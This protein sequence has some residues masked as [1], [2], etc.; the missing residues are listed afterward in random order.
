MLLAA[1]ANP[2]AQLKLSPP[3]RNIGNDRGLDGMLTTGATPLLRAAKALDAPAIAALLAKGA[4]LSAGQLARHHA[5]HGGG[6]ARLGRRRHARLLSH[7]GHAAAIDRVAEAAAQ[8]RR[9]HQRA[10]TRAA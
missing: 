2:N 6:R 4:D 7:R 9:R 10:R 5:D 1:G 8:G 3:F